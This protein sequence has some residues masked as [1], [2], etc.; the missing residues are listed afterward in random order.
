MCVCSK[1][2]ILWFTGIKVKVEKL[3][4]NDCY[5]AGKKRIFRMIIKNL[6]HV[7]QTGDV[8]ERES[9]KGEALLCVRCYILFLIFFFMNNENVIMKLF[10]FWFTLHLPEFLMPPLFLDHSLPHIRSLSS[11]FWSFFFSQIVFLGHRLLF[12]E[13]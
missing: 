4:L 8:W 12:G 7:V 10:F 1:T 2:K 13:K 11:F 6:R 9:E 3:K 5:W